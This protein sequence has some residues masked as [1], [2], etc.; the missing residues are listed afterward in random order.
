[1]NRQ[2]QTHPADQV[3]GHPTIDPVPC[4]QSASFL[5]K[6]P[7]PPAGNQRP[8]RSRPSIQF[9][10]VPQNALT[11]AGIREND[12]NRI[13][14][15]D[16]EWLRFSKSASP[17]PE[18]REIRRNR[19]SP[20]TQLASFRKNRIDPVPGPNRPSF[21]KSASPPTK[22]AQNRPIDPYENI[23]GPTPDG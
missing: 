23:H 20:R 5:R 9:G 18:I 6:R 19:S 7:S 11:R 1:M 13:L 17:Q 10:F 2:S 21:C 8:N 16:P 14:S 3:A 4:P 15:P 22:N 12:R